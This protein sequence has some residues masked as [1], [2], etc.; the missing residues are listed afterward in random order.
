MTEATRSDLLYGVR[1]IAVFLGL[2]ES[3]V[4]AMTKTKKIPYFKFGGKVA[5]RKSTL[6]SWMD[7]QTGVA[8]K[9]QMIIVGGA[10]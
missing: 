5:V 3:A 6:L 1:D 4:Y 8:A 10:A 7:G 9:H 2:S